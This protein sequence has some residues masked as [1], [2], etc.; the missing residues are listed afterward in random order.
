LNEVNLGILTVQLQVIADFHCQSPK[1][2]KHLKSCS[3]IM[4][5]KN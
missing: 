2:I 5:E 4:I 3:Y 1:L